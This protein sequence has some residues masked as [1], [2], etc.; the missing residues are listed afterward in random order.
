MRDVIY[1]DNNATT[2]VAPSVLAKMNEVYSLPINS[3]ANHSL[4]QMGSK[5][6]AEARQNLK[7]LLNAN[8]YEITFTGSG[9]EA[10]NLILFGSKVKKI[11]FCEI[12]HASVFNSRPEHSEIFEV[13]A[14]ENG[15]VDIAD[16]EKKLEAVTDKNF[17]VSVM[18]A[19]NETGAIQ[20]IEK[21]TKLVHQ[22]G[23]LMHC[24]IVQGAGKVTI[25]LEK[26][27]V[28]FASIS[29]HKING[30][31]GVGAALRRKGLDISPIIVGGSQEGYKRAGTLNTAGIVGF[32]EA[33][34]VAETKVA[35]Y[36]SKV[37]ALRDFIDSEI[38]KIG[39][40][41]VKIFCSEV[42]RLPNTTFIS[43]RN[44]SSQTQLMHFD[45]KGI[46]V[47]AGATC[48][49]GSLKASRILKAMNAEESFAGGA[50]RVSLNDESTKEEAEKFIAAWK[51]FFEKSQQK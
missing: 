16:L 2:K 35:I 44:A 17:L 46:C 41:D 33:C 21:I 31:Q 22:K 32:G 37:K 38:S 18:Y 30:P 40:K 24:D 28:D 8:N 47:S 36:G 34:K 19:N 42:D 25:D 11:F 50:V 48:S 4:G 26:L 39:G 45:L 5:M 15:L 29:A 6:V 49:S 12:E 7:D 51:E 10:S 9:T 14:L 43:I 23:G 3:S 1:F 27:N 13:K 20:P